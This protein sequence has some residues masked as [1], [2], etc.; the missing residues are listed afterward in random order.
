[1][2]ERVFIEQGMKRM[3]LED[4]LRGEL[5]KAGFTNS[6]VMKTPLVTRIVVNVT[7]PSLAIGK[8][9]QN[10]R[11][12]TD[13]IE[14]RFKIDNPQIEIK[15]IETPELSAKV[16][17]DKAKSL[18]ERGFSWRSI[19]YRTVRDIVNAN[20]QGVEL[21]LSGKLTGKGGRKRKQRI[22]HGYMKK[23]GGQVDLVD[24][25]KATAYPKAGAIGI[26]LRIVRPE[27]V[28]PDKVR[29]KEE[30]ERRE[31]GA[32]AEQ[33][34]IEAAEKEKAAKEEEKAKAGEVK[35]AGEKK[36]DS[37]K[38]EASKR[39]KEEELK[40]ETAVEEKTEEAKETATEEKKEK[41]EGVKEEEKEE[42]RVEEKEEAKGEKEQVAQNGEDK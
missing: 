35:E 25:A 2:I 1:M 16:M 37:G 40:G 27:T 4:Y 10:I 13:T 7:R 11:T 20:A 3:Q 21:I 12:L 36:A 15:E 8:G 32:R 41:K 18:I 33:E 19:A 5:Y 17:A 29:I 14:K 23:V 26:K 24:Y 6:E 34:K 39:E 22:A 30:L 38:K 31:A 42:N 9:G 28:F